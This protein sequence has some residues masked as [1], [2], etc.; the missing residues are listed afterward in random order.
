MRRIILGLLFL[1]AVLMDSQA[2]GQPVV[3]ASFL[4]LE[5]MLDSSKFTRMQAFAWNEE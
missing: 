3:R 4:N 2:Y 5:R 1:T